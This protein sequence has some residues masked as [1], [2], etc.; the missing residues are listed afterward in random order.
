MPAKQ[1]RLLVCSKPL[2]ERFGREFFRG[3]PKTPGVYLM[4][5]GRGRLLYVGQSHNLRQ[6]IGS[7]RHVHPDRNSRKLV[8]LV[9]AVER[10]EWEECGTHDAAKLRENLLLREKRPR[11]NSLNTWPKAHCFI[12]L[13]WLAEGCEFSFTRE[14]PAGKE[15]F[16]GAFKS[17]CLTGYV[18]LLRLLWTALHQTTSPYEYPRALL[19]EKPPKRF[20]VDSRDAARLDS[21]EWRD[22]LTQFF[23][24]ES[25]CLSE[26]IKANL[27]TDDALSLFHRNLLAE[28]FVRLEDFFKRGP[29]RNAELRQKHLLSDKIIGQEALDDLLATQTKRI[30]E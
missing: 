30:H 4:F 26:M 21:T 20:L 3:L 27:P 19:L 23:H 7:Y 11:F 17:G 22:L 8:R 2:S 6:R 5:D 14:L 16:H 1:L 9:H 18:S 13:Q 24:G 10:I 29:V 15:H 28:D 12:G 25:F